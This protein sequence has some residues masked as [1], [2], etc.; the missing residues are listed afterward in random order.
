MRWAVS[1]PT[2]FFFVTLFIHIIP[3][4]P[5]PV[6]PEFPVVFETF[7]NVLSSPLLLPF[8]YAIV[9]KA[10]NSAILI[11]VLG[12]WEILGLANAPAEIAVLLR[13]RATAIGFQEVGCMELL[14][15]AFGV[16][17]FFSSLG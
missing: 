15:V 10:L 17:F 11:G 9:S 8:V 3:L 16:S 7:V 4:L 14:R 12:L 2:C 5:G 13:V 6:S 1:S